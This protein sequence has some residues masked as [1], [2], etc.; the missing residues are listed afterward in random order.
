MTNKLGTNWQQILGHSSE[1]TFIEAKRILDSATG[2][3]RAIPE[4]CTHTFCLL[5]GD[6][7]LTLSKSV[8]A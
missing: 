1:L 3:S 7:A 2:D 5:W 6:R 4:C 8:G